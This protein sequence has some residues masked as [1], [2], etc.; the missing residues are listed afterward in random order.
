MHGTAHKARMKRYAAGGDLPADASACALCRT[1]ARA[2]DRLTALLEAAA[3]APAPA[4]DV[5]PRVASR[6]ADAEGSAR[7]RALRPAWRLWTAELVRAPL[8]YAALT[9]LAAGVWVGGATAPRFTG[10]ADAQATGEFLDGSSL[11]GPP[12]DSVGEQYFAIDAGDVAGS[13]SPRQGDS[14]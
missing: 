8:A 1:E 4:V 13:E 5:W 10:A 6:L 7:A 14:L 9:A 3:A 2:Y 12:S 11:D